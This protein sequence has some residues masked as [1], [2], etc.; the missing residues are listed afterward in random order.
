MINVWD[1]Q[2]AENIRVTTVDDEIFSGK[3]ISVDD[4]E[5]ESDLG[6]DEDSI[7]IW[8]GERAIGLKQSEIKSIEVLR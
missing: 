8:D 2:E 4:V 7:S 6:F 5:E 1:Y 3:V